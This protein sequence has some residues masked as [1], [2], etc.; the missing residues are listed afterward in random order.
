MTRWY[1]H[2]LRDMIAHPGCVTS[3]DGNVWFR[4]VPEPYSSTFIER[5]SAAY[6]VLTGKAHAVKW[7]DVGELEKALS[8]EQAARLS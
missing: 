5:L 4:A 7:P 8:P 1:V 6:M 2:R 3:P